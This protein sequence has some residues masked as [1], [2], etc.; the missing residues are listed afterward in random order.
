MKTTF[1]SLAIL[2]LVSAMNLNRTGMSDKTAPVEADNQFV[3]GPGTTTPEEYLEDADADFDFDE[4]DFEEREARKPRKGDDEPASEGDD[5][6][7]E[8]EGDE[9]ESEGDESEDDSEPD[10]DDVSEFLNGCQ[11]I[12]NNYADEDELEEDSDDEVRELG[13]KCKKLFEGEAKER[14]GKGELEL[15]EGDFFAASVALFEN[16]SEETKGNRDSK[17][18][19]NDIQDKPDFAG[20]D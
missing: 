13:K 15:P 20:W 8:S 10:M 9:S 14:Q 19:F 6:E 17:A 4:D 16:I 11:W 2:A 7:S 1:V 12:A 18:A 3:G 5:D